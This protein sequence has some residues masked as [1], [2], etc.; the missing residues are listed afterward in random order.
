[1]L[2]LPLL[3][4]AQPKPG[5]ISFYIGG[6]LMSNDYMHHEVF[7]HIPSS[8]G[9]GKHH[10]V[11]LTSSLAYH[12]NTKWSTGLTVSF[13]HFGLEDR[14][15]EYYMTTYMAS[16]KR[17]WLTYRWLQLS[18]TFSGGIKSWH[19]EK[20][21]KDMDQKM[22]SAFHFCPV[23][24]GYNGDRFLFEIS[25]GFGASGILQFGAWYRF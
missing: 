25:P 15:V 19:L 5:N 22:R 11:I 13:D 2:L 16:V 3:L 24:I 12:W 8:T 7:H 6:G 10:C 17:T 20:G 14:S 21:E 23:N 4:P 1:M 18:S 9:S